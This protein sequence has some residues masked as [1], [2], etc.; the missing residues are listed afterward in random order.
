MLQRKP[1]AEVAEGRDQGLMKGVIQER[2]RSVA[3]ALIAAGVNALVR[4][5]SVVV[6]IGRAGD[7][8][9]PVLGLNESIP[10]NSQRT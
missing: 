10:T 3:A 9:I 6:A 5:A 1:F 4:V 7:E 8:R 2:I